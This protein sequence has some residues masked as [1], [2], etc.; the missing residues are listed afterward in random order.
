MNGVIYV[1]NSK[2][3]KLFSS[4]VRVDSTYLST[5]SC[6]RSCL[7]KQNGC[8]AENSYL[9]II[10]KRLNNESSHLS[11]LDLAK[12]E[13]KYI[14][15]SYKEIPENT[16][17]R[18]HVCGDSRT[19]NGSRLINKAVGRWLKRGGKAVFSYTH[20][21]DHITR[22]IWNNVSMLASIDSIDQVK[23]ARQNGY[24]PAIIVANHIDKKSYYI[25]GSD[26]K[27][28]PCPSQT[29][30]IKCGNCKLCFNADRLF[31][32]NMGIAFEAHGIKKNYIKN[33]LI[34]V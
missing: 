1:K 23:H 17:L 13:A 24:A 20:C 2:N 3:S 7:L 14:D 16:Y 30:H 12:I 8:Y 19:I 15:L 25:S 34:K 31:N 10:N 26:I 11:M 22:D 9:G 4:N 27:W 5:K 29:H 32:N 21:W 33:R 18:L 28:I 6:P